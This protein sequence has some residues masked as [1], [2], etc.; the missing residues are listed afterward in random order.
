MPDVLNEKTRVVAAGEKPISFQ[1]DK[2]GTLVLVGGSEG[3]VIEYTLGTVPPKKGKLKVYTYTQ[4]INLRDGS[5]V[6]AWYKHNPTLKFT[7]SYAKI[8][9]VPL[10]V[11]YASSVETGEGDASHLVD[12][13]VASYWHTMY[14]VTLAKYPHWVDFD[15]GSQKNMKGFV[16]TG[17]NDSGNGRVKDFEI[18]VSQDGKEW[19]NPVLKGSLKDT[20]EPQ[21]VLFAAPVK[22]RY[23]RFRA[24]SEQHGNDYATGAE[25]N[26][27]AE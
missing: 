13:D 12:G 7:M 27:I 4:P 21:R 25:F 8:E 9:S 5:T 11:V 26:L 20:A 3:Q 22:A 23:V 10:E 18:Y 17:R 15:A 1:R 24:L 19:G 2:Q 16:Y 14:S 6:T